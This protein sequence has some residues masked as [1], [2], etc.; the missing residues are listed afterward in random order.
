MVTSGAV[1]VAVLK[2]GTTQWMAD[3]YPL[4]RK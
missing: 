2:G 3:Q 4:E 1:D